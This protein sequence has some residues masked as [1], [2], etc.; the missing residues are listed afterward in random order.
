MSVSPVKYLFDLDMENHQNGSRS[1]SDAKADLLISKAYDEGYQKG[2][3]EGEQTKS[4]RLLQAQLNEINNISKQCATM[5]SA[6]EKAEKQALGHA[7]SLSL[8]VGR[9]LANELVARFPDAELNPLIKEC[10]MSL[11]DAPHLVIR[12][13][14]DI[15]DLSKKNAQEYIAASGFT[16]RLVV[17]GDPDISLG[18]GHIEWVNGGVV[19]ST[20]SINEQIDTSINSFLDA[21]EIP[22]NEIINED[23]LSDAIVDDGQSQLINNQPLENKE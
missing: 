14:P 21:H 17:M 7:I 6:S 13:H 12:T 16:G 11:E 10:L 19:R 23:N 20:K 22:N 1:K 3:K 5:L 8:S 9:K 18:D 2:L 15:A 4:A